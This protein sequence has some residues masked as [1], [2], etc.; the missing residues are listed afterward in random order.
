MEDV[1]WASN[2]VGFRGA[3]VNSP[4]NEGKSPETE[5]SLLNLSGA[6]EEVVGGAGVA[7]R[8]FAV[9]AADWEFV[10][11]VWTPAS[12]QHR[13]SRPR[14]PKKRPGSWSESGNGS[15]RIGKKMSRN[16]GK[17][18]ALITKCYGSDRFQLQQQHRYKRNEES[19]RFSREK[20]ESRGRTER[21]GGG[22]R[23]AGDKLFS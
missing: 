3:R 16:S 12:D 18:E 1:I 9:A 2:L 11:G 15:E 8:R 4:R 17:E 13:R 21:F 22:R 10:G 23:P 14:L 6:Q 5:R 19:D 7:N 20:S